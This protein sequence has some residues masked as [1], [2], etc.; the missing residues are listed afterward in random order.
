MK[1]ETSNKFFYRIIYDLIDISTT[2]NKDYWIFHFV[3]FETEF[4]IIYTHKFKSKTIEI[5][6]KVIYIIETKYKNRVVFFQSDD[7]RV[8]NDK[9]D[10]FITL[11]EIIFE[12][13]AL[14]TSTQNDYI[15]RLKAILLI[16]V[17]AIRIQVGLLKYLWL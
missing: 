6:V 3:C 1:F 15:E 5:I 14:N 4:H 9:F 10:A 8:L 17:K 7:E 11:K 13:S 2:I 16:K 12:N